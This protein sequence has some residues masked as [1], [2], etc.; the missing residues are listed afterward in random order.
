M[1]ATQ[2]STF[3]CGPKGT[4]SVVSGDLFPTN[5]TYIV[6]I[7][8]NT[9][10]AQWTTTAYVNGVQLGTTNYA[11]NPTIGYVGLTQQGFAPS[12]V[13]G[14]QWNY[15]ALSTALLPVFTQQPASGVVPAGAA[16]TNIVAALANASGGRLFYQWYTNDIPVSGATNASLIFN[17]ASSG[18][19][20]ANYYVVVTNNY[21]AV[22]SSVASLT[23]YVTNPNPT[24]I[25]FSAANNQLTLS[26]PVDHLGWMLQMQTN[27]LSL[28]LGTNW[29]NVNGSTTVTNMLIPVNLTNDGVFY[30]LIYSP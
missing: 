8:L 5:G 20:D 19:T 29:V 9:L 18:N 21:G 13:S 25:T 11:I 15:L 1:Q 28:G 24:N 22:T 27:S 16:Y 12:A 14:I 10:G 17:P 23:V 30:R 3:F 26:W 4:L 6:E 2:N 7:L